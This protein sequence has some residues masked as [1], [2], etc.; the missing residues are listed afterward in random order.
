MNC[1]VCNRQFG[2]WARL[3][4]DASRQVCRRCRREGVRQLQLIIASIDYSPDFFDNL[5]RFGMT[6]AKYHV[7]AA[8]LARL[9]LDLLLES[10]RNLETQ[11][12]VPAGTIELLNRKRHDWLAA[13]ATTREMIGPVAEL[14][15]HSVIESWRTR[16]SVPSSPTCQLFPVKG[17]I[18]HWEEPARLFEQRTQRKYIGQSSGISVRLAKGVY[19]RVG[20]FQGTP[21][22]STYLADL[23]P[24]VLHLTNER[25]CFT[26]PQRSVAIPYKRIINIGGFHDGI[27]IH[28]GP[29]NPTILRIPFPELTTNLIKLAAM[30]T[31]T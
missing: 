26:N 19:Y 17:E 18:C 27:A 31:G 22:D 15:R 8:D 7:P 1:L 28:A 11:E 21:I 3:K 16:I 6:A 10:Y 24:G 25:I 9:R 23:G 4:G 13:S 2:I 30:P 12:S 29:K 14:E 20:A 5:A